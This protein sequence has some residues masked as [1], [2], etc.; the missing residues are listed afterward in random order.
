ME[1]VFVGPDLWATG[2]SPCWLLFSLEGFVCNQEPFLWRVISVACS[3]KTLA[4]WG[5]VQPLT[6]DKVTATRVRRKDGNT[7][8][9]GSRVARVQQ[10]V[11]WVKISG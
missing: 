7:N 9:T 2:E 4:L 8:V 11:L 10:G 6:G 1:G 5:P 3:L